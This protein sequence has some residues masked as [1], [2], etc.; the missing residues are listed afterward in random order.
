[1]S[2]QILKNVHVSDYKIQKYPNWVWN[3]K[4]AMHV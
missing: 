2:Y 1:M 4:Y 3:P